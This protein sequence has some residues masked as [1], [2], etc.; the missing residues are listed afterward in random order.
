[1]HR[2]GK[3]LADL[4]GFDAARVP[5]YSTYDLSAQA[6]IGDTATLI[7]SVEN[8]ADKSPPITLRRE[9]G[10]VYAEHYD[11]VGRRFAVSLKA[12]F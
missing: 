6:E 10:W 2:R 7:F 4:S 1:M 11:I 9:I 3:A 12:A 8:L 5:A